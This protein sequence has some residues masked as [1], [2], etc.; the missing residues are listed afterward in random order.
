MI[1]K[2]LSTP[3]TSFTEP[4]PVNTAVVPKEESVV[5]SKKRL[6]KIA[7][8]INQAFQFADNAGEHYNSGNRL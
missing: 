7:Q 3:T 5:D 8:E 6:E 4:L 2:Y 1:P